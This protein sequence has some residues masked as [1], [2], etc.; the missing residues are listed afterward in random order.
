MFASILFCVVTCIAMAQQMPIDIQLAKAYF[1]DAKAVSDH[2]HGT[3]WGQPLYGPLLFLDPDTHTVVAN[4]ADRE[5]KLMPRDGVYVGKMPDEIVPANTAIRW[6]GVDW[7]MVMWPL[8]E[9]LQ[10][11]LRLLMHECFH[12]VAPHIGLAATDTPPPNH[13][14]T[15]EGRIWMQME[16]RALEQAMWRQGAARKEAVADALYFRAYRR[17][18]FPGGAAEEN[19]QETNEGLAEYTGFKLSTASAAEFVM[20]EDAALRQAHDRHPNFVRSFAYVSG[21]AYG[22]LLDYAAPTWRKGLTP[23]SDLGALLARS[24]GI[25]LPAPN[26]KEAVR[27][28]QAYQGDEII[29][30]ETQRNRERQARLTAARKRFVDDPVLILPVGEQFS[31]GFDPNHVLSVDESSTVYEGGQVSDIW[32]VLHSPD[33]FL[34]V[35]R[36]NRV[37]RV[38][39]P[40]PVNSQ[41]RPLKGEGWTLE[42]APGW[43]L[44]PGPRPG[45]STLKQQ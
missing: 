25:K 22:I 35:R 44:A 42:L 37:L 39:V 10:P 7:T 4:Q 2:D 38:Q 34:I 19:L 1:Q 15:L 18:L 32:G 5:G 11:R 27:R 30:L 36:A 16:W 12:R 33:G 14:D 9:F 26:K 23:Q 24:A 29:A 40:A 31:Y 28:A 43:S 6:A 13:L 41:E 20:V 45:D 21:P 3:L 8:P 17:S